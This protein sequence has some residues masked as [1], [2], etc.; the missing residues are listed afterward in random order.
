[1]GETISN[2]NPNAGENAGILLDGDNPRLPQ[3]S[4][5]CRRT[6]HSTWLADTLLE[7]VT[8]CLL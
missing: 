7:W 4:V 3:H 2:K 6:S 5:C 1:V 8:S